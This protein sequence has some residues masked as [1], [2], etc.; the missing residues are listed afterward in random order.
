MSETVKRYMTERRDYSPRWLSE[1][2]IAF[3]ST[4]SG[5]A[6]IW[7]LSLA[8]G[9]LTQRTFGRPVQQFWA[10]PDR[11]EYL[12]TIEYDG[13]EREQPLT[14]G[15]GGKEPVFLLNRPKVHHSVAGLTADRLYYLANARHPRWHDVCVLD[16]QSGQETILFQNDEHWMCSSRGLSPDAKTVAFTSL[17]N[18]HIENR[19]YLTDT[20]SGKTRILYPEETYAVHH[21]AWAP[22]KNGFYFCQNRNADFMYVAY[23]DLT[24]GSFRTVYR[25]PHDCVLALPSPDGSRLA[26]VVNDGGNSRLLLVDLESG[27]E[28][29]A[30]PLPAGVM[31]AK[32]SAAESMAWSPEGNRIAFPFTS[33]AHPARLFVWDIPSNSLRCL[34]PG[35]DCLSEEDLTEPVLRE[36]VSF[37]GLVI[38]YWLYLPKGKEEKNLPLMIEIHGGP[39]SQMVNAYND[40][41][42]YV[43]SQGIAVVAP[44]IRGSFGY[45]IR[46][47]RLDDMDKRL[48]SV[49]DIECLAHHLLRSGLADPKKMIVSGTSYGG[50]MTLS[51]AA[52]MPKLWACCVGIVGMF[53]LVT[54]LENTSEF[55]RA[56]RETEYGFLATDREMLYRVS[57]IAKVDDI[58]R[59]LMVVHGANDPRVP[60]TE[61]EQVVARLK[62]AGKE[63]FYLRYEDEGHGVSKMKNRIDCYTKIAAFIKEHLGE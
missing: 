51:C 8:D 44:N 33:G 31:R 59:P 5:S 7:E 14:L 56:S 37:D 20:V 17:R 55:R 62:A 39:A 36:Y 23:Y 10:Y 46:Y 38:P 28:L 11:Q 35:Y 24:D 13:N 57:P 18:T 2:R 52:R 25:Q 43:V 41:I 49:K 9:S 4:R 50:F 26:V 1:E 47:C 15:F 40:Y 16:R 34:T 61:T 54:F 42:Q 3:L 21:F 32:N 48:D 22:D 60:V 12:Y 6:Q 58:E 63:V 30:A 45:G 29:A 53:N 19:L 27:R